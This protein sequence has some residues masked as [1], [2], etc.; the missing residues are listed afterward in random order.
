MPKYNTTTKIILPQERKKK[1]TIPVLE[2]IIKKLYYV[3]NF[4]SDKKTQKTEN[5]ELLHHTLISYGVI[6]KISKTKLYVI[7]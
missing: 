5:K 7:N 1:G 6:I 4:N 2:Q 3:H